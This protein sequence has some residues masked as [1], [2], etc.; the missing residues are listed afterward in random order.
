MLL[1]AYQYSGMSGCCGIIL[2]QHN[3][4]KLLPIRYPDDVYDRY[5]NRELDDDDWVRKTTSSTINS[6]NA[7]NIP[8]V[9]LRTAAQSQNASIP[10]NFSWS[11]PNSLSKY[12][13]YFHF[14][15]I[16]KLEAGQQR[17]LTINLNGQHYL[18]E[19]IK[20]DYLNP[21]TI[22]QTDQP[23]SGQ[24]L[25]FSISAAEGTKLPPILSA[26][27]FFVLKELPNKPTA[28]DD[29]MFSSLFYLPCEYCAQFAANLHE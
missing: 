8:D 4:K 27:E 26:V 7:Y 23:S 28:V 16:E 18:T 22:V 2:L 13:I 11:L 12:Y 19:S 9:V 5:W 1:N 10:L 17:E 6:Q 29:G 20:L 3:L 25:Y 15:E 14:A 21:I 24:R